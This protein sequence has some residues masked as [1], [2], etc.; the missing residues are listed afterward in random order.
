MPNVMA[1]KG[2]A[3]GWHGATKDDGNGQ[4]VLQ[5]QAALQE[6][7]ETPKKSGAAP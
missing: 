2:Q 5:D 7:P 1:T 6:L 3:T 4:K